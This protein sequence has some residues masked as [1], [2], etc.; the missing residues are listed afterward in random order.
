[1]DEQ[2]PGPRD[3]RISDADRHHV[4]EVLRQ[5]AGDGRLDLDELDQRLEDAWAAKVYTDLVPIVADLPGDRN[6]PTPVA[7]P[8]PM[9]VSRPPLPGPG[10]A[11]RHTSS[12]AVMSGAERKGIWEV[13]DSYTAFT[14]MGG[15][16]IDL[17]EAVFTSREVVI[18]ANAVMGGVEIFVNAGTHVINDVVGIMGGSTLTNKVL[19]ALSE[20][21]P[22]VR[23]RGVA[24][25]GGVDISRRQMPGEPKP[26]RLPKHQR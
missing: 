21:S 4:A 10:V 23:V 5:A 24:L 9:T 15:I 14:L 17:R 26:P 3:L 22:V 13:G 7:P 1:M 25:M 20:D 18:T 6:L 8:T 16:Q 19:P 11:T 12:F 2:Q